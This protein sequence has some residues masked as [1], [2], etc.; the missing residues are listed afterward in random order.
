[1]KRR[2]IITVLSLVIIFTI[3][4]CKK[5]FLNRPPLSAPTAGTFYANDADVLS[6]T[7]P[8]Y[9]ASWGPYNGTAMNA[10]GDVLG[11]IL[12]GIIITTVELLSISQFLQLMQAG[13]S[14]QLI[15]LFGRKLPMPMLWLIIYKTLPPAQRRLVRIRAWPNAGLCVRQLIITLL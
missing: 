2:I 9:T 14:R 3:L 4:G 6:G 5:S 7:G 8:L 12:S 10:I 1:M 15:M 11:G 13:H